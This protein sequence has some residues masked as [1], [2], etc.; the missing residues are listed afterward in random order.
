ML[1]EVVLKSIEK[2]ER[3]ILIQAMETSE[4][5]YKKTDDEMEEIENQD[6][7]FNLTK[8]VLL[9]KTHVGNAD[10]YH[11]YA[12]TFA[13][14][15]E[16]DLACDILECGLKR[17]PK[18]VDLLA[19]YLAYG[20]KCDKFKKCEQFYIT[21]DGIPRK[22]WNWRAFDFSVDYQLARLEQGEDEKDVKQIVEKLVEEF[23]KYL[24]N[25]EH[26]YLAEATMYKCFGERNSE[27]I[28]LIKATKNLIKSPKCSLRLADIKFE[29]GDF[30][31]ALELLNKCKIYVL[32]PQPDIGLGYLYL[33]SALC[34]LTL[35]YNVSGIEVPQIFDESKVKEI[36]SDYRIIRRMLMQTKMLKDFKELINVLEIKTGLP[37]YEE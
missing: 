17:F 6:K 21:L 8:A 28:T 10:D 30:N 37:Y 5:L 32:T 27:E 15:N 33:L 20:I 26:C 25:D 13:R 19:D 35:F 4:L 7:I 34:K 23:H 2:T 18:S 29:E 22:F 12:I 14:R 1:Y 31:A 36:Y 11:N 24:P 16:E 3:V 9:A